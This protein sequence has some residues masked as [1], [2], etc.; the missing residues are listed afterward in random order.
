M[1]KLLKGVAVLAAVAALSAAPAH[2]QVKVGVAGTGLFSLESGGGSDFGGMALVG[3]G[4][5]TSPIGFRVDGT[6]SKSDGVTSI[7]GTG[8]VTYAFKTA[9]TSM[10]HPYLIV[11]GGIIRQSGGGESVTKPMAKAGAGFDYMASPN[12]VIFAEPTFDMFFYGDEFGGTQ[13]GL[14]ANVGVK[15]ALGGK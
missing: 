8:D 2:A 15:F 14:Q 9:E 10:F 7:L 1:K 4:G 5:T 3:F 6:F 11:G 13:K 12:L